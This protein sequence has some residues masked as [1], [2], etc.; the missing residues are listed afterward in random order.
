MERRVVF[1]K[2]Y[3]IWKKETAE[4]YRVEYAKVAEPLLKEKW[5]KLINLTNWKTSYP[6]MIAVIGDHITWSHENNA[7]Y[8]V[9]VVDN[10][11][12]RNQLKK[13][14]AHSQSSD[15]CKIFKTLAEGDAFLK[16]HGF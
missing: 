3:G 8:S 9:Y 4:Q 6:E 5:A 1:S 10:P 12:T 16:A 13:M 11:I 15:A 2:I 14:I 7:V